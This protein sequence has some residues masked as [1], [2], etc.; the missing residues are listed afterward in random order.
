MNTSRTVAGLSLR[1]T[2]AFIF[3][4]EGTLVDTVVPTL[5]CWSETLAQFGFEFRTS[6]LRPYSG[7]DGRDMLGRLI[8]QSKLHAVQA[9]ILKVQGTLYREKFLELAQPIPGVRE[10]FACLKERGYRVALATTCEPDELKRYCALINACE[11]IDVI[12]C[13]ADVNK[14]KP[15]PDLIALAL[16]K[17]RKRN[18]SAAVMVGD[19]PFDAM[20]ALAAGTKAVGVLTGYFPAEDLHQAGAQE[21]FRNPT[22]L[23]SRLQ[24]EPEIQAAS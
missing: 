4:V 9:R 22:E 1:D 18:A 5:R 19:T 14:G 2:E 8:P 3:D 7:M 11:F 21:V 20:A 24:E 13:G 17:L 10:L 6:D 23:L 15:H 16:K 12:A